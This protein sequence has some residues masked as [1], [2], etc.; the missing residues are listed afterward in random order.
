MQS[1]NA[2]RDEKL[3][4]LHAA[5]RVHARRARDAER[6]RGFDRHLFG[7]FIASVKQQNKAAQQGS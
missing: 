3:S 2:T 6:G 4:A 5:M 7:L 1:E